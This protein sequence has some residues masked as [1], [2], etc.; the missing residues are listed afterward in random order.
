MSKKCNLLED[1][2]MSPL[3]FSFA[4]IY[5]IH[6]ILVFLKNK[7]NYLK[8]STFE[9]FFKKYNILSFIFSFENIFIFI[10]YNNGNFKSYRTKHK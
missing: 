10:T 9:C 8:D 1:L 3:N 2:K 7:L 4:M 6:E 5:L